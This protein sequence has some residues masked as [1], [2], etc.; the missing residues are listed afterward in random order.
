MRR[1]ET[2]DVHRRGC[3]ILFVR[4][5]KVFS[6]VEKVLIINV[7]PLLPFANMKPANDDVNCKNE[8]SLIHTFSVR[9]IKRFMAYIYLEIM[10]DSV[11]DGRWEISLVA[12]N[13]FQSEIRIFHSHTFV[14]RVTSFV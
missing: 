14:R 7:E 5:Y 6:S 8:K 10:R 12:F 13:A 1:G 11:S 4:Q 3:D 9:R 2:Y